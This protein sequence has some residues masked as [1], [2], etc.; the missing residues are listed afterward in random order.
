[1]IGKKV[2]ESKPI[3]LAE[4]DELLKDRKKDV[5]ELSYEQS[6]TLKHARKFAKVTTAKSKKLFEELTQ[7]QGLNDEFKVKLID[8]LPKD[9]DTLKLLV[10]K[11]VPLSDEKLNEILGIIKKYA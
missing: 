4:V 8:V 3:S 9:M 2:I 7:M 10:P 6:M 1:M 5:E 11:N